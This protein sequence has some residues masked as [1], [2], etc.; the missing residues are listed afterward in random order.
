MSARLLVGWVAVC[1]LGLS[2]C[3]DAQDHIH[4]ARAL[5]YE[6]KPELALKQYR[7]ALDIIERDESPEAKVLQA[8]ALKGAADVYYLELRDFRRAVEVYEELIRDC[9]EAPESLEARVQLADILQTQFH[10]LR[11]AI[12]ALVAAIERNP[13][14][15]AELEYRVARLYFE[16]GDFQQVT[17]EAKKVLKLYE[18][19]PYVDDAML[20]QAQ[21]LAMMEGRQ[22]EG[23]RVMEQLVEQF[24]ESELVPFALYEMGKAKADFGERE[25]AITLWVRALGTHPDP[26]MVQGSINRVR[27]QIIERSPANVSRQYAFDRAARRPGAA[28][29]SATV[30]PKTS[31]EA[32]GASRNEATHEAGD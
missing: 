11:G 8:R 32:M 14:Q 21:A 19:S 22:G 10:N 6:K 17:L 29:A 4:R 28:P 20:L 26:K 7:L 24:P 23:L 1:A 16:L 25:A 31:L 15:S 30:A 5:T 9:P 18:T 12:N 3:E 27:K 13:P 2:G